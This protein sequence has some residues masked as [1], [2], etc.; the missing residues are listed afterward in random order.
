MSLVALSYYGNWLY[1]EKKNR[2]MFAYKCG[3]NNLNSYKWHVSCEIVLAIENDGFKMV[4]NF[5]QRQTKKYCETFR[6]KKKHDILV[7]NVWFPA[8]YVAFWHCSLQFTHVLVGVCVGAL[9]GLGCVWGECVWVF[10]CCFL[11]IPRTIVGLLVCFG[12]NIHFSPSLQVNRENS[13]FRGKC[14]NDNDMTVRSSS[15]LFVCLFVFCFVLF[16]FVL[17]LLCFVFVFLFVFVFFCLFVCLSF[18]D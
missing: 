10:I 11:L 16:C 7:A 12:P 14:N 13:F 8:V 2:I 4:R 9:F 3:D 15:V 6:K 5:P 18:I 1:I 17:F